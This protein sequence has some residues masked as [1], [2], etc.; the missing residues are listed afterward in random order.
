MAS[1]GIVFVIW[2]ICSHCSI[3]LKLVFD[4]LF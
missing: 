3:I 2:N 1:S 4:I